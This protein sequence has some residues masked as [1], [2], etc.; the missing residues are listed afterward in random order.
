[1]LA[2]GLFVLVVAALVAAVVGLIRPRLAS[3]HT[4]LTSFMA[5]NVASA[6]A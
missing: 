4:E 6:R 1:M 5:G 2:L 3:V